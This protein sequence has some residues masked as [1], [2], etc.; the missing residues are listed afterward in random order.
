ML[1]ICWFTYQVQNTVVLKTVPGQ[2]D[3]DES[4][5]DWSGHWAWELPTSTVCGLRSGWG[6]ASALSIMLLLAL[7]QC[8]D[9]LLPHPTHF[10]W[11]AISP[12]PVTLCLCP[13]ITQVSFLFF[14]QSLSRQD[15]S[16]C[17]SG[18]R[19]AALILALLCPSDFPS[20]WG[21]LPCACPL[22]TATILFWVRGLMIVSSL[23]AVVCL[24]SLASRH[25]QSF[26]N[27]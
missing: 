2:E 24:G 20:L 16:T 17:C 27:S 10:T 23:R 25:S 14:T 22:W 18:E 15:L 19:V 5:W 1:N 9:F 26:R 13:F 8:S 4:A 12:P 11:G 6:T 7:T 3:W 21:L